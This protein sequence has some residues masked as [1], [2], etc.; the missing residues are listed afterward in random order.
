MSSAPT[1]TCP[2]SAAVFTAY[3][4]GLDQLH[5][6]T[7]LTDDAAA[8]TRANTQH[9]TGIPRPWALTATTPCCQRAGHRHLTFTC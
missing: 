8:T 3:A 5:V 1:V 2:A 4:M 7:T 9:P 6:C